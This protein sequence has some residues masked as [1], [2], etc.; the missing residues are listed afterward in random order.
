MVRSTERHVCRVSAV[1][2]R[3]IANHRRNHWHD[4]FDNATR[5]VHTKLHTMQTFLGVSG[6]V[7][8]IQC[9]RVRIDGS[10]KSRTRWCTYAVS[11]MCRIASLLESLVLFHC[12]S[13]IT[14]GRRR[15]QFGGLLDDD[16]MMWHEFDHAQVLVLADI[17]TSLSGH[18]VRLRTKPHRTCQ[19]RSS[20]GNMRARRTLRFTEFHDAATWYSMSGPSYRGW[21]LPHCAN[22]M[23]A[24]SGQ[25]NTRPLCVQVCGVLIRKQITRMDRPHWIGCHICVRSQ[26]VKREMHKEHTKHTACRPIRGHPQRIRQF[27]AGR[28]M[29]LVLSFVVWRRSNLFNSINPIAVESS[30]SQWIWGFFSKQITTTLTTYANRN[31]CWTAK[32]FFL[33]VLVL[34]DIVRI[35]RFRS[36]QRFVWYL[37]ANLIPLSFFSPSVSRNQLP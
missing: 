16:T 3:D 13:T 30:M 14:L 4:D 29:Y 32:V 26:S 8:S 34:L 25:S 10:V 35:I 36:N 9:L 6:M 18:S 19:V 27:S 20:A 22:K 37:V 21:D 11:R 17:N 5:D 31:D 23:R 12:T 7:D 33:F 1:Q 24:G 28:V 2:S 15:W